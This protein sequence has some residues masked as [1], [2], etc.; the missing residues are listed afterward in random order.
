MPVA[1]GAYSIA[2]GISNFHVASA[3]S[4]ECSFIRS[5][6]PKAFAAAEIVGIAGEMGA[7]ISQSQC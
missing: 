7:Q 2:G 3:Y 1:A 5:W 6:V 4:W